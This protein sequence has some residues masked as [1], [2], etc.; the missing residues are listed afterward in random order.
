MDFAEEGDA[1][2]DDFRVLRLGGEAKGG[3][4][5]VGGVWETGEHVL[6]RAAL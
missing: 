1:A 6:G 4:F 2:A 3:S 5:R